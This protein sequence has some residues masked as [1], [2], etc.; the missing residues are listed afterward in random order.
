ML[1]KFRFICRGPSQTCM[2]L[3]SATSDSH[4]KALK[5]ETPKPCSW[6][7]SLREAQAL[8]LTD[9]IGPDCGV[10]HLEALLT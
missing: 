8:E 3:L 9:I 6:F 4:W 5:L 1:P 2:E 7:T 10:W